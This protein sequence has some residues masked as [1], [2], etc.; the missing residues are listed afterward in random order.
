MDTT[1]NRIL[2]WALAVSLVL[3]MGVA[4]V[5]PG[6]EEPG[7]GVGAMFPILAL[8]AIAVGAGTLF[9]RRRALAGPIQSGTLDLASDAGRQ[10]AFAAF[11]L[12]LVLSESVGIYGLVLSLLSGDPLYAVGFGLAGLALLYLH[13]P[14]ASDLKPPPGMQSRMHDSTPIA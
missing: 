6:P 8:V 1:Q 4:H 9:Y 10:K 12:N 11:I 14:G 13:R 3:Y 2:W 5:V 7:Q